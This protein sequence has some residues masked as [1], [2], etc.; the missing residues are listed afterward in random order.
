MINGNKIKAL[1]SLMDKEPALKPRLQAALVQMIKEEPLKFK[2]ALEE[3]YGFAVPGYIK[4]ILVNIKREEAAEEIK[5]YSRAG[6]P[7]LLKGMFLIARIINPYADI[8]EISDK[9]DL[10]RKDLSAELDCGFDIFHKA[11]A[12]S[13][14]FF[15]KERYRLESLTC[16]VKVLSLPDIIAE[17][18]GS[19]FAI[20][21]LYCCA[22]S[23]FEVKA[24]I[25]DNGGKVM[26]RL[27]DKYSYEPVYVDVFA[28]GSFVGEDECGIYAAARGF[29]WSGALITPLTNKQIIRR[30][31]A[32]LIYVYSKNGDE[33]ALSI[34]RNCLTRAR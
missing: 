14:Y 15:V 34:L 27:R 30:F 13:R 8:K 25:F 16:G 33:S 17:R 3:S 22:A 32:N 1:I 19:S 11:E 28:G 12:L 21:S 9:F 23:L 20:A 24:D 31:L 26:V 7:S 10:V 2:T 5:A 4:D 29:S 6:A 18:R